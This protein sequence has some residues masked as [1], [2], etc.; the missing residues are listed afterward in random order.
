MGQRSVKKILVV[1]DSAADLAKLKNI[2]VDAGHTVVT[3]AS[4]GEAIV[5]AKSEKPD[6][7]FMVIVMEGADGFEAT[8]EI[9]KDSDTNSIPVVFVSS[10]NRKA[11]HPWPE[12]QGGKTLITK[13]YT[14]EQILNEIDALS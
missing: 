12:L 10:N 14:A 5:K 11:D 7:I 6:L 4:G 13:P 2:V 9:A 3:A 1:D 8:R